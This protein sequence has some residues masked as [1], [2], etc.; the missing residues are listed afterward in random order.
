[1]SEHTNMRTRSLERKGASDSHDSNSYAQN[2][3][4]NIAKFE[5][6]D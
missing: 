1:M 4:P 2:Q 3:T 5:G 6:E